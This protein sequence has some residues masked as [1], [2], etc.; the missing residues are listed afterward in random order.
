MRLYLRNVR[1]VIGVCLATCDRRYTVGYNI[2]I[3]DLPQYSKVRS[4]LSYTDYLHTS[5]GRSISLIIRAMSYVENPRRAI[6]PLRS[7][8]SAYA[9]TFLS[10]TTILTF[11]I[12]ELQ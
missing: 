11:L 8:V 2:N 10:Q 6:V 1:P 12:R 9:L 4:A 3:S 5:I 7:T